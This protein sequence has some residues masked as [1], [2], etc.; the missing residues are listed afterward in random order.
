M[1]DIENTT[2]DIYQDGIKQGWQHF[3]ADELDEAERISRDLINQY[4][5]KSGCHFLLGHIHRLR[6]QFQ[7][8]AD[9][10]L[11]ALANDP[12]GDNN[13]Y[14]YYWLAVVYG[15]KDWIDNDPAYIYDERKSEEYYKAA[16]NCQYF[17]PQVLYH[18][19]HFLKGQDKIDLME[20]GI[21]RFPDMPQFYILLAEHYGYQ[22]MSK[23]Q[24]ASLQRAVDRGLTSIS[25][26]YNLGLIFL[27]ERKYQVAKSHFEQ[28]LAA[29]SQPYDFAINYYL[30]R[31]HE[32]MNKPSLA[33]QNYLEVYQNETGNQDC[34]FGLFGLV[35]TYVDNGQRNK[36]DELI[37]NLKID[38]DLIFDSGR[39]TGGPVR[40]DDHVIDSISIENFT[41]VYQKLSKLKLDPA[42][43][44]LNGKIWLLRYF[45]AAQLQ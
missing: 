16:R 17:P 42:T 20:D 41:E 35:T 29:C 30:G 39:V 24:L 11:I 21:T 6:E 12:D 22:G 25:L 27:K 10:F 37:L 5:T 28:A 44:L 23:M 33:E 9:E 38:K 18:F 45:L 13:G 43:P 1:G 2:Q 3:D 8:A 32:L 19:E 31:V 7:S 36:L 14:I 4:P 34:L 26:Q 40:L 15:L